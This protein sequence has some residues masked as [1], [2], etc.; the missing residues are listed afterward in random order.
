M[1]EVE[2]IVYYK[3]Q[4]GQT[5]A[6]VAKAFCVAERLIV[7]ENRLRAELCE[8]QILRIPTQRGNAFT[9]HEQATKALCCGSDKRYEEKNGT[10]ILYP[11]MRVIL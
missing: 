4:K 7:K 11:G 5:L 6:K 2:F 9:A 8:G 3:V 10:D 1:L